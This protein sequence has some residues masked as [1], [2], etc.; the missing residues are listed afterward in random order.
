MRDRGRCVTCGGRGTDVSH[1]LGK[2]AYP[3]LRFD[4]RNV[5]L[6]CRGCHSAHHNGSTLYETWVEGPDGSRGILD[7]L[8]ACPK[9]KL[10]LDEIESELKAQL[11]D[12]IC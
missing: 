6:Q 9:G 7:V 10:D 4:L 2:G 3:H 12:I 1:L 11:S 5:A 8:R